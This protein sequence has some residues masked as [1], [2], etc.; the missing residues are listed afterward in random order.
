[1][2]KDEAN[3]RANEIGKTNP[4]LFQKLKDTVEADKKGLNF[5]DRLI[6]QLGVEN[7][8]RAKFVWESIKA[9]KTKEEKNNYVNEMR[10]KGIIS[11]QV[12]QQLGELKSKGY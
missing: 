10:T 4:E 6:M 9:F 11:D 1:M 8:E 7:G 5:N 3:A 2:P 12:F